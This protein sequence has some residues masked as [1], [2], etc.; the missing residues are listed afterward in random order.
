MSICFCLKILHEGYK[1]DISRTQMLRK[2]Q[3][4]KFT[5]IE[6]N[7]TVI[8]DVGNQKMKHKAGNTQHLWR[9]KETRVL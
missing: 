5:N 7:K 6:K 9:E 1:C 2:I 4:S 3:Q 8:A